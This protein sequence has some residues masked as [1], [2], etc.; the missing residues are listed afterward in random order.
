ESLN[1][2]LLAAEVEETKLQAVK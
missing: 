2:P 1:I